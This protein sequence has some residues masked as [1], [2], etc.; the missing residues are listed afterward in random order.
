M[1]QDF[2]Q[3]HSMAS[4]HQPTIQSDFL[5]ARLHQDWEE[6][7]REGRSIVAKAVPKANRASFRDG[8]QKLEEKGCKAD[9]LF[10]CLYVFLNSRK[11][12]ERFRTRQLK[13]PWKEELNPITVRLERV[14]K[15]ME[16]LDK[17]TG[18]TTVSGVATLMEG[19][20][21]WDCDLDL[22]AF[23]R[24]KVLHVDLRGTIEQYLG[25]L[26]TLCDALP[27]RDIVNNYGHAVA[28]AYVCI[29]A[30]KLSFEARCSLLR[31]LLRCFY[32]SLADR[33]QRGAVMENWA[34][35]NEFKRAYPLFWGRAQGFLTTKHK[36]PANTPKIDWKRFIN[37]GCL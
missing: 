2:L 23:A 35:I 1:H 8:F 30:P 16:K 20:G 33:G 4:I 36:T 3:R 28:A 21:C 10:P 24:F 19:D 29:A 32:S 5:Q 37:L 17:N 26:T 25:E 9:V 22:D 12:V 13:F 7:E 14:L 31:D 27:R 11:K 15:E 6:F 18:T 34:R